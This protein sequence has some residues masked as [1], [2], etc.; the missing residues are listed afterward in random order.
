MSRSE[1]R[2]KVLFLVSGSIAA[3][4]SA[5]VVSRLVQQ[6]HEVQVVLSPGARKFIGDS[7]F[8]GLT[9]RPV[10]T[11]VFQPGHQMDHIRLG[12][13]CDLAILCPASADQIAK[14]ATGLADDPVGALFLAHDFTKPFL[15]APA[16]NTRMLAHPATQ[17]SLA[18][19]ASWGVKVLGT[20]S[21][22]LA[23]GDE[24]AGKL[25]EP[26]EIL[27]EIRAALASRPLDWRPTASGPR[28]LVTSG[29]TREPIDGVRSIA[30]TST[31][32]TGAAIADALAARGMQVTF[33][34][35]KGS[36]LPAS[37]CERV[38]FETFQDLDHA[39]KRELSRGGYSS[40]VHLAAV[41]D[42]GVRSVE[43]AG[44]QVI[45][46]EG[47]VDS[48][49]DLVLKLSRNPKLVDRIKEYAPAPAPKL[50]AFKLTHTPDGDLRRQAVERLAANP[51][52]DYVV[53][54]DLSEIDPA[55]GAH[56]GRVFSRDLEVAMEFETKQELGAGLA[57]LLCDEPRRMR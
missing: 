15:L 4:K 11:D 51:A 14:L 6:G 27:S 29:G 32:A 28:V 10:I 30:N 39:L 5:H 54:N 2:S 57:A 43:T 44:G 41:S 13:W 12:Q 55:R 23:C 31:G 50:V 22:T 19:L 47:K 1:A 53:H 3:Y 36:A 24:G 45:P 34:H 46:R 20:A 17:A 56:L 35:A 26:E 25:L 38:A 8:E 18:K 9:G 21:G 16:M 40:V 52:V 33:I 49:E 42:Y 7:T 37:P 48:G